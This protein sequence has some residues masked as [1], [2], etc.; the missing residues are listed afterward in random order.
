MSAR[1]GRTRQVA[2]VAAL[3]F[4]KLPVEHFL[5]EQRENSI[6]ITVANYS[7]HSLATRT[8]PC[9]VIA[10][11]SPGR[12]NQPSAED[13]PLVSVRRISST[14]NKTSFANSFVANSFVANF[15]WIR[16]RAVARPQRNPKGI[17]NNLKTFSNQRNT[18][19]SF[20]LTNTLKDKLWNI[21]FETQTL[22]HKAGNLNKLVQPVGI[23]APLNLQFSFAH[24]EAGMMQ[25]ASPPNSRA[26]IRAVEKSALK[27][28]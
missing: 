25:L 27:L 21:K 22:Y 8:P 2:P 5:S 9:V 17:L 23:L 3:S 14:S 20:F 19:C 15:P 1:S 18:V 7:N 28:V 16:P 10:R 26:K 13:K 24:F 4:E 11:C 6:K 12:P